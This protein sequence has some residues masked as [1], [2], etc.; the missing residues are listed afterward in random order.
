MNRAVCKTSVTA[1]SDTCITDGAA[2]APVGGVFVLSMDLSVS[3]IEW[4]HVAVLSTTIDCSA[5][6]VQHKHATDIYSGDACD[7]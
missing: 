5:I 7:R 2:S 6:G 3:C 4:R 1:N